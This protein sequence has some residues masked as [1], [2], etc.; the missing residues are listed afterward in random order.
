MSDTD[1]PLRRYLDRIG[2][3][4]EIRPD[5]ITLERLVRAHR[6]AIPFENL[7]IPLGRGISLDPGRLF[8]KLV[9]RRRGGYCFEQNALFLAM[10][11]AIGFDA[12]PLLAR[13]WLATEQTPPRTHTLNL[14]RLDGEELVADVGFG[15]SFAPPL[16]LAAGEEAATPD[17]ARHRLVEDAEHGWMLERDGGDGWQRQYSFTLDRVWPAD[18]EAGNHFTATRP[19]TRFTTLRIVSGTLSDGYASL[20][21][22]TLTT[23]RMGV[24]QA[25]EIGDAEDYRRTLQK[26]F[27]LDLDP[28]EV[29]GLDLFHA[30]AEV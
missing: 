1:D 26:T 13:V 8:D 3:A 23:S 16:R 9:D 20:I 22:R 10:A 11:Q 4:G 12:R 29:A 27:G 24:A 17:G 7:D 28:E 15:G 18:L 2:L 21:G 5:R 25:R 14:V 6:L 30:T 19:D